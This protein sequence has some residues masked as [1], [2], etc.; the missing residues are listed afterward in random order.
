MC[1]GDAR[2]N[3]VIS[4][5]HKDVLVAQVCEWLHSPVHGIV[6][7]LLA[8]TKSD[9]QLNKPK[10]EHFVAMLGVQAFAS[11]SQKLLFLAN[12]VKG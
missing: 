11:S 10:E 1:L 4:E 2:E 3:S 5:L 7:R 8:W 6:Y 12:D 9:L